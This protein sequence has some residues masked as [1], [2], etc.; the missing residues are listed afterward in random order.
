M[1][2]KEIVLPGKIAVSSSEQVCSIYDNSRVSKLQFNL[3]NGK[4]ITYGGLAWLNQSD[5]F[6]GTEYIEA[7]GRGIYRG[8][9][10]CFDITGRI[11]RRIY[12]SMDNEIAGDSYTS[13]ND[14]W[15]L[16]TTQKRG[17]PKTAPFEGL[18]PMLSLVIMDFTQKKIIKRIDSIGRSPNI[19]L[20]ESPWLFDESSF[21]YSVSGENRLVNDGDTVNPIEEGVAGVYVYD[22]NIDKRKLL[23]P[24]GRLAIASPVSLQL[25]YVKDQSIWVLDLKD[26]TEKLLYEAGSKEKISNIHWTPD[27]K[28][29]YLVFFDYYLMDSFTSGERLIEVRT[30]EGMQV[31]G[32]GHGFRK[33]TWK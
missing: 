31:K 6:V 19:Q 8:N 11:S 15:V 27:G 24:G 16:F 25:A 21:I 3:R 13:R 14:K 28:Y 18:T 22:L 23:V 33:Y 7:N 10:V 12:E 4:T 9:I 1:S 2:E 5:S 32:I 30:G 20:H 17:D 26:K 29:I